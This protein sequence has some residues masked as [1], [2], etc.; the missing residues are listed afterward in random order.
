MTDLTSTQGIVALAAAGTAGVALIFSLVL[1]V[2]LR[3]LR[4]AQRMVLGNA[5][6]RDL[7]DQAARLEMGFADLREWVEETLERTAMRMETV[8][9]RLDGC[10]TYRAL[11]RYDAYNELSG[12]QSSSLALLDSHR[13]G[14]VLSSIV[15]RDQARL[16][17]KQI[18]HGEAEIELSPEE[19]EAVESALA[20]ARQAA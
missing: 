17:V 14:V 20:P 5:G 6:E 2:K 12:H 11:V 13:S 3:R 16:Y 18:I 10:V 7:V 8:E 15:H 1:A 19:R 4:R 9:Q